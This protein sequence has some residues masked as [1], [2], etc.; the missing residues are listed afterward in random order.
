[1]QDVGCPDPA[2]EVER[3]ESMRS[4]VA[5]LWRREIDGAMLH[6]LALYN[7]RMAGLRFLAVFALSV[8]IGGLA[9]LALT[10]PVLFA[11]LQSQDAVAG[12]ELAGLS[13]GAMFRSFQTVCWFAGGA[14]LAL[15]G[16]RAAL[17]PRPR[18]LALRG[19]LVLGMLGISLGTTFAVIPRID[20]I[21]R[22]TAGPIA[23]LP[24]DHP[25][26]AAFNRL[27]G[28]SSGLM[29][30]TIAGGL[31]LLWFETTDAH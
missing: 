25:T 23:S 7:R 5:M 10:A 27:H 26:R 22:D 29:L 24:A 13:F 20:R 18:R 3:T 8:W 11:A 21:R 12:R 16:V 19:W 15:L 31:A 9:A 17:G 4:C 14:L 6:S 1:M 2:S 28:L 30:V